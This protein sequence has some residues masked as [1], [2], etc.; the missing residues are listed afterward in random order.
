MDHFCDALVRMRQEIADIEKGRMDLIVNRLKVWAPEPAERCNDR[1]V[2]GGA[3]CWSSSRSPVFRDRGRRVLAWRKY[4]CRAFWDENSR[5]VKSRG[6]EGEKSSPVHKG[7]SQL[8][9]HGRVYLCF[10]V[11]VCVRS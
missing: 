7:Q 6:Q 8:A 2:C 11:Y 5:L 4:N 10:C 1:W 3:Q 9:W